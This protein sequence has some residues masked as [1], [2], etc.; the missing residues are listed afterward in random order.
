MRAFQQQ[1]QQQQQLPLTFD[2]TKR[3]RKNFYNFGNERP[4][5]LTLCFIILIFFFTTRVF[6][7]NKEWYHSDNYVAKKCRPLPPIQQPEL[8]TLSSQRRGRFRRVQDAIRHAWRG[9]ANAI[10]FDCSTSPLGSTIPHD[11]LSPVSGTAFSWLNYAAT[12]HDSIDTLY[13]ANLT[14]EYDQAVQWLTR[15]DI[16]TTSIQATKT[17]GMSFLGHV[18]FIYPFLLHLIS[19]SF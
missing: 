13:L 12:L 8:S 7:T 3:R 1:Q 18:P 16:Q 4:P 9:Y 10:S 2:K 6:R 5:I 17:F 11:D 19:H 15:Y 14:E